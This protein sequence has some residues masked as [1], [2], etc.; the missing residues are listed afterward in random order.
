MKVAVSV[1]QAA[2][3]QADTRYWNNL[4]NEIQM[5]VLNKSG[6]GSIEIRNT[7]GELLASVPVTAGDQLIYLRQ[8][9]SGGD[10][11]V[12]SQSLPVKNLATEII[13]EKQVTLQ[14]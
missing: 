10:V 4:P 7:L 9:V 13:F 12:F 2:L 14:N 5:A 8:K 6:Q 11:K 3:T 1:G